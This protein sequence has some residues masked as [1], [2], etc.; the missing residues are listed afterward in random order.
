MS[1]EIA[2]LRKQSAEIQ[3]QLLLIEEQIS[4]YIA[5]TDIPL[6]L[7][8][9]REH[10]R[11]Q[12]QAVDERLA[13]L[14][15]PIDSDPTGVVVLLPA[16]DCPYRG[17]EAF[18][19]EHA[20]NYFGRQT[21]VA[22]LVA[23][24]D[25]TNFVAV[26]GPSGSGKSSLVRAGLMTALNVQGQLPGSRHWQIVVI[27]PFDDPLRSL[28]QMLV[29]QLTADLT[30][31]KRIEEIRT[32]ATSLHRAT[33]PIADVLAALRQK[34]GYPARLVVIIDQFEETFTLCGDD[35]VRRSFLN[36][37]LAASETSWVTIVFTLRADFYGHILAEERF[38]KRVDAGLV[39]VLPMTIGERRTAIEQP[40]LA[41]G[42]RFEEG[43]VARILD[44]VEHE[45]GQLPLLEFALTE[46]WERQTPAGVLTHAAY[47]AI[48]EV[49]GA[50]A[51]RADQT[52]K[53]LKQDEQQM[54]RRI[55]TRLVRVTQPEENAEDTKRRI[56]LYEL[57][58]VFQPLVQKLAD[59]RLLVTGRDE[60]SG[61][62]TIEVAHE[63]LI[64]KWQELQSWLNSDRAFLLWRQRLRTMVSGWL[65]S[66]KEE[67]AL[68]RGVQLN[69]SEGWSSARSHDLSEQERAYIAA[70]R[71]AV[72]RE[73][74]AAEERR[75]RELRLIE[76]R[77]EAERQR[78]ETQAQAATALRRRALW[79]VGALAVA[80]LAAG[81]AFW[82]YDQSSRALTNETA[83]RQAE[84]NARQTEEA[85]S[86]ALLV[87]VA[88]R[89]AAE[90]SEAAQRSAAEQ[91]SRL[92]QARYLAN[93]AAFYRKTDPQLALLLA[94]EAVSSTYG[95]DGYTT[96]EANAALR[97][98]LQPTYQPRSI[99]NAHADSVLAVTFSPDGQTLA[100]G[101]ADNSIILWEVSSGQP[102][103][104]LN[105]HT[106]NVLAVAFSPDGQT[107]ASGSA[108]NNIIRWE[109]S[110]GR[111]IFTLKEPTEDI[112]TAFALQNGLPITTLTKP[113]GD[114]SAMVFSSDGQ[115]LAS[116]SSDSN[117]IL[118]ELSSGQPTSLQGATR[119][120]SAM[121]FSPLGRILA[122]GSSGTGIILWESK[123]VPD[124]LTLI[125]HHQ[126]PA[127][128]AVF[129]PQGNLVASAG[130]DGILHVWDA[131]TGAIKLELRGH[132]TGRT[133]ET[134]CPVCIQR[135]NFDS[136]GAKLLSAGWDGTARL[137]DV[138]TKQSI[139]LVAYQDRL[140]DAKFSPDGAL[141]A[142]AS[143]EDRQILLWDTSSVTVTAAI[144]GTFANQI[145]FS[146][147]GKLLVA[148]GGDGTLL[149]ID[150]HN[151]EKKWQ[152]QEQQALLNAVFSPNGQ[153][154]ATA[155]IEGSATIWS[156]ATGDPFATLRGHTKAIYTI[157]YSG[158]GDLIATASDDGS[159][160]V[161]DASTGK[162]RFVLRGHTAGVFDVAF[163]PD[164]LQLA[165]S[166]VDSTIRLWNLKTGR[167]EAILPDAKGLENLINW[168]IGAVLAGGI[169]A[170]G[171]INSN[172]ILDVNYDS[173]GSRIVAAGLDGSVTVYVADSDALLTMADAQITR[174][175]TCQERNQFLYEEQDC[176]NDEPV[177][178][179]GN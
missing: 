72:D 41:A 37:L 134:R 158:Q 38:G 16:V 76:A 113:T 6:T 159:A 58:P 176:G 115:I 86:A 164:G 33:L 1:Q 90:A 81:V 74:Q 109:V 27:R 3:R 35:S 91:Q 85:V 106:D 93:Q 139:V 65:A 51:K 94:R 28:A 92:A 156:V 162:A 10:K 34:P 45:A 131:H 129:N 171:V 135:I 62:E 116:G 79:L 42:R 143:V 57:E 32:L 114:V 87:E 12:L 172:G 151:G 2:S 68:L 117:I 152:Q 153:Y 103:T 55:F 82:F 88:T 141:I 111:P 36:T 108:D 25:E 75:Q 125:G 99:L 101:S 110:S 60:Q 140:T 145:N 48:G 124:R 166:G 22:K 147:D 179:P 15:A 47:E 5:E 138:Q 119:S 78:A 98:L 154:I 136:T 95:A 128:Y 80:L 132:G 89:T 39:N 107:L 169:A 26:V 4:K 177:V 127:W 105:A 63:A 161:W 84:A 61:A 43:L 8:N 149:I 70:S 142:T 24:L 50:I 155:G 66:G 130:Q 73:A 53:G 150:T 118:W 144:T 64:R 96:I 52:L 59:A 67:E 146:P 165:T 29:D 20:A 21:M 54:V 49:A 83:A 160:R 44:D 19:L 121:A 71:I 40:A 148:A 178:T 174:N 13:N 97:G 120:V 173:S 18:E 122:S 11:S 102:I 30:P 112:P 77:A 123:D 157:V 100:S 175:F 46:L 23:K 170:N 126:E 133:T 168:D 56:A 14:T 69:E 31:I 7:L 167:L 137:W 104:T 17:L 9:D 163:R